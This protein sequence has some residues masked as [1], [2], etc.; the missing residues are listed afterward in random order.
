[1]KVDSWD[2]LELIPTVMATLVLAAF[3]VRG[4]DLDGFDGGGD[5]GVV[6]VF[7]SVDAGVGIR[8]NKIVMHE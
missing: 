8:I 5:S 1:M 7:E 6:S 3:V 2:H 4:G